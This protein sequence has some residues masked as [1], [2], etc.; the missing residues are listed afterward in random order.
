MNES[1]PKRVNAATYGSIPASLSILAKASSFAFFCLASLLAVGVDFEEFDPGFCFHAFG[2]FDGLKAG[3]VA[4]GLALGFDGFDGSNNASI[5]ACLL[6][7][8]CRMVGFLLL[9]IFEKRPSSLR[10]YVLLAM[11]L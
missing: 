7:T 2:A 5:W 9:A 10:L 3:L 8:F 4:A 1:Y 6:A 11:D